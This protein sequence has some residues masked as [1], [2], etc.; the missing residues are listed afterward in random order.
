MLLLLTFFTYM[1]MLASPAHLHMPHLFTHCL[2]TIICVMLI[3][4]ES[5]FFYF[6]FVW[7]VFSVTCCLCFITFVMDVVLVAYNKL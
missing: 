5:L 2:R 6:A 1:L 7:L 3:F 4:Y